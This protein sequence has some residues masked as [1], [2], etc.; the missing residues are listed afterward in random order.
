MD[1]K[2]RQAY[3]T[4]L[5]AEPLDHINQI[6]ENYNKGVLDH[7]IPRYQIYS[8]HDTQIANILYHIFPELDWDYVR[9]ASYFTMEL[10]VNHNC[11]DAITYVRNFDTCF[12]V[13]LMFNGKYM[14]LKR[15]T[16][17][18]DS[19]IE[20]KPWDGWQPGGENELPMSDEQLDEAFILEKLYD[21]NIKDF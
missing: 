13:R 21:F 2:A 14:N 16:L 15:G 9:Y 10:R 17:F 19:A 20:E 3:I 18:R 8:A 4:K 5:F 11:F 6:Y 1:D 7:Q 12:K